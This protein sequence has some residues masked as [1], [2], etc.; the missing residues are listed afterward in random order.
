VPLE[1]RWFS[2]HAKTSPKAGLLLAGLVLAVSG[3]GR[4]VALAGESHF[5]V[6]EF[7]MNTSTSGPEG[8]GVERVLDQASASVH[9]KIEHASEVLHPTVDGLATGAHLAVDRLAGV[10]T[11]ASHTFGAKGEQLKDLQQKLS[12]DCRTYVR[13]KPA[14]ALAIAA[15]AGFV[16]SRL[17]RPR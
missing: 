1:C 17:L 5:L 16:I 4:S 2:Q 11:Q 9:G 12:E 14:T 13:E 7:N 6:K 15:V 8:H 3:T 10:A